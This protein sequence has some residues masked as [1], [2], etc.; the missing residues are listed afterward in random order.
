MIGGNKNLIP[1]LELDST[2]FLKVTKL[3]RSEENLPKLTKREILELLIIDEI[4]WLRELRCWSHLSIITGHRKSR[5]N[6][7][8]WC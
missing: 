4:S 1:H 5:A 6:L 8:E 2:Q 7:L 3:E